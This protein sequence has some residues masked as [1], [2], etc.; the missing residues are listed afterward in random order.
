LRGRGR[1]GEPIPV[2]DYDGDGQTSLAE[3]HTFAVIHAQ[4][5]DIPLRTSEVYLKRI[6]P[7]GASSLV[8]PFS[9]HMPFE[10]LRE[11]ATPAQVAALEALS[12]DLRLV[13]IDRGQETLDVSAKAIENRDRCDSELRKS[14]PKYFEYCQSIRVA[15]VNRWPE[16]ANPWSAQL[17]EIVDKDGTEITRTIEAHPSFAALRA[18]Q[19]ERKRLTD[20]RWERDRQ[21]AKSQRLLRL[22][23]E[24]AVVG[25]LRTNAPDEQWQRYVQLVALENQTLLPTMSSRAA[26]EIR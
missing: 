2:V 9:I 25:N 3:A 10:R 20:E 7:F 23:E 13:G 26:T 1:G 21:Y 6:V 18:I 24:V 17:A 16:L 4:S 8:G 15:L 12:S 14:A 11:S 19:A 5:I 22:L